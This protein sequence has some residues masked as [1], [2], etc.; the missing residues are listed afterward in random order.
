MFVYGLVLF[1]PSNQSFE[2]DPCNNLLS[3]ID[4]LYPQYVCAEVQGFET[5]RLV[6]QRDQRTTGPNQTL[7]EGFFHTDL[8]LAEWFAVDELDGR[9][10][11]M[12]Q[13]KGEVSCAW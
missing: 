4:L 11:P 9:P 13:M 8:V 7:S 1:D 2:V 10:Q 3:S 12:V 6:E 5:V